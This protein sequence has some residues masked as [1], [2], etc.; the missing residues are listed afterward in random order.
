MAGNPTRGICLY[1]TDEPV[2]PPR[3]LKAGPL[4]AEFEA[5]NLRY[6]RFHG[7]EMIRAVSYIVRDKNWGTYNPRLSN[8]VIEEAEG[9]FSVR[10]DA[11]TGDDSQ[12]FT[13]SA[14]IT[15]T[16]D[17]A[18]RFEGTGTAKYDFLTNRTGFVVLHPIDGVAG[19]PAVIEH[20]DGRVVDTK[21]P[22]LIDP[23]QPMMDLRAITHEFSPGAKVR[24]LMEG[25]TFEMEDQRNW[26]DASYKTYVRPLALPWPYTLS[27][28]ETIVQAV[29]LAV[30][31]TPRAG[32]GAGAGEVT[33]MLGDAGALV[34]PLGVGLDPDDLGTVEAHLQT[35]NQ[36][37]VR[38]VICHFDP[39]RGHDTASLSKQVALARRLGAEPWLEAI[40]ATVEGWRDEVASLGAMVDGLGR[41]FPV[42]MLSP[43]SDLKCTL[44]GSVW[45]PC[46][47][48][49]DLFTAARS[50]FGP[51]RL[52]GGMFSYFT[53]LNRKRPPTAAMDLVS[54]TTSA[55]VHAGD[56]RSVT[57]SLE[58]MPHIARSVRAI[59]GGKPFVVGP[60]AIGM[61]DNPYGAEVAVNP[62]DIRQAMNR[63]D[64]RQRGLLGAAFDVGYFAHMA[65]GG[66]SAIALGGLAGPF[67]VVPEKTPWGQPY[68]DE[69]GGVFQVFHVRR[70]LAALS[71][72]TLHEVRISSP[73]AVQAIAARTARG[74]ELLVANLTGEGVHLALEGIGPVAVTM[75]SAERF[76]EAAQDKAAFDAPG[77]APLQGTLHLDAYA[78]AR[79]LMVG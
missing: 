53:E 75:L 25:D 15:G 63:N 73:R 58:A 21:F 49:E 6:I 39:R 68:F 71:G 19:S 66:A 79:L 38:H 17:G 9:R 69:A 43:A 77:G 62:R 74:V 4:T 40:I 16:A 8:L 13:Y 2:E 52:A 48:A 18:L 3:L 47:P 14:R 37:G 67:G 54:F 45:P 11:E 35:L 57:E 61:R 7:I 70:A 1:G 24:C 20:V 41:P 55:M 10:Y 78:V 32:A 28:G 42:V 12:T 34:P 36:I 5:G 65:Y 29:S 31:G 51:V 44:P 56:D 27:K 33:L 64:P 23:V 60:S 30:T 26:T 22:A 46:P 76:A 59:V 72:G 50:T